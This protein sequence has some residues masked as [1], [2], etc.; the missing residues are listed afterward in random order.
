MLAKRLSRPERRGIVLVLVLAML[1]LLALIGVTFATFSGQSR[2]NNRNYQQSLLQ[3]QAEELMDFALA[4]LITDTSDVRSAIRG[5]SLA[6]DMFGNDASTNGFLPLNPTTGGPFFITGVAPTTL[7]GQAAV[8]LTT[9]IQSN[10]LNFFGFNFTRWI[11]KVGYNLNPG[12][13]SGQPPNQSFEI[14]LDNKTGTN[15][16]FTVA[17][18]DGDTQ[19]AP[20]PTSNP[21]ALFTTLNNPTLGTTTTPLKTPLPGFFLGQFLTGGTPTNNEFP[22]VLDGRWLRAFNGPGISSTVSSVTNVPNSVYG[23]FRYNGVLN[24]PVGNNVPP[25]GP[26]FVG[27]DEDYDACDLEN[28]F[29]AIQSADGQVTIPSFHRPAV[30]RN[31]TGLNNPVPINDW[32]NINPLNANNL[33]AGVA[34]SASRI[35]RPRNIDGHDAA[36]F[37][38]LVPNTATGQITYDVDNDADGVTDSVWLDLGFPARPDSSGRLYKPLFAFMVIGLNGRIPL[39]TAG[40]F[41]GN[42][43]GI[44]VVPGTLPNIDG[45]PSQALHL[46][47]SP[48][49]IDPTYALQNAFNPVPNNGFSDPIAAFA[50]PQIGVV[51]G[52]ATLF[53]HNSQVDNG[54]VDVRLTQYRN[55]LAGTRPQPN[56]TA[57]GSFGTNGDNNF[58]AI[59]GSAATTVR[60]PYFMPN[61]IAE[62]FDAAGNVIDQVQFDANTG[63]PY[64]ERNSPPVAGRWGEAQSIPGVPFPNPLATGPA[65]INVVGPNYSSQGGML[66][67]QVRAGYSMDIGDLMNGLPRDAADDNFNSF[68]PFPGGPLVTNQ[69]IGEV[70]DLDAYDSAGALLFPV[71]RMRRW[72]TPADINGTGSVSTWSP[73]A[74]APNR[75]A[76]ALGR[77]EFTSYFRPPGAPGV[78]NTNYTVAA[79][80]GDVTSSNGFALGSISF[81][82]STPANPNP[83]YTGGPANEAPALI[84]ASPTVAPTPLVSP[85]YLPDLTNNPLHSFESFRIPNQAYNPPG[86]PTPPPIF[87]PQQLGGAPT[88]LNFDTTPGIQPNP[89]PTPPLV[90]GAGGGAP[91]QYPTYDMAV[92]ANT[93]SDGLNEADEMNLYQPNPLLDAPFGPSDLEWLYRQQDVDGASLTSR[94]SQ[95]APISFTNTID[96]A[97]RRK[98]FS[99]DFWDLNNFVWTNDNPG[100]TF[101]TNS[102]FTSNPTLSAIDPA[103]GASVQLANTGFLSYGANRNAVSSTVSLAQRDKKINLNYPLPVSNDPN[104]PV[105]Q[106][107]I[108]DTYELLKVILPPK[109]VDTPEELAQLSQFVINIVDFRDPDCAMTHWVNPD[110]QLAGVLAPNAMAP[111]VTTGTTPVPPTSVTLEFKGFVPLPV[112]GSPPIQNIQLDQYGM[113]YNPVAINEVLAYSYQYITAPNATP[114][115]ANRFFAE[116]VNTLTSPELSTSLVP[117]V[118]AAL[119]NPALNLGGYAN[120][121]TTTANPLTIDPYSG[122]S[123]DIV[124]TA[125]DPYSRPDPY[126]G[127]LVPYGNTFG[128]TPLHAS[129]FTPPTGLP[130]VQATLTPLAQ[131]TAPGVTPQQP[132]IPLPLTPGVNGL[133]TDY[134][135]AFGNAAPGTTVELNS[136]APG[137]TWPVPAPN[138]FPPQSNNTTYYI[139]NN[140]PSLTQTLAVT[141]DPTVTPPP[142]PSPIPI[143][144]GCLP[145]PVL[146]TLLPPTPT[147]QNPNTHTLPVNYLTTIPVPIGVQAAPIYYW[148]CLRRPA[149]PF[150]PVSAINPM[151]VVDSVRF[152]YIEASAVVSPTSKTPNGVPIPTQPPSTTNSNAVYS[153]Q[154]FQPY[155]GGHAVPVPQVGTP[156]P[157]V[158]T[159]PPPPPVDPRYGYSEQIVVP[160]PASQLLNTQGIYFVE[161]NANFLGTQKVYH[162]LGWANEYEQGSFNSLAEPWDYFPFNDRDFTSV[163]EL[164]LVPGSSPGLFTKQFVEFA[165]SFNNIS[166]V[167][168]SPGALSVSQVVPQATGPTGL[169]N[170]NPA[171]GLG[172]PPIPPTPPTIFALQA[173]TTASTPL[174]YPATPLFYAAAGPPALLTPVAPPHT[175]P[176]LI[177]KFFYSAYGGNNTLDPGGVVGGYAADGW[178]KMFEF[179]EVPSQMIGAIG[180]VAN[181]MNFDWSRQDMKPGQL[182]LNLIIDEEVFF[183]VLGRQTIAQGNGQF[184][185]FS[186]ATG[187]TSP[188]TPHDQFT[189]T[190]LNFDQIQAIPTGGTLSTLAG[191]PSTLL[192][193]AGNYVPGGNNPNTAG[194]VAPWGLPL[195]EGTPPIPMVVTS[196]LANGAPA[197]AYPIWNQSAFYGGLLAL[198]PITGYFSVLNNP[199]ATPPQAT[200]PY[201]NGL[202]AAWIQFL[203]LRHG[204]SGYMYGYGQGA[205]GQ[206]VLI[207]SSA[208]VPGMNGVAGGTAI[209]AE[210]PFHSLSYPDIDFTVMRPAALPPG[211][212]NTSTAPP[213]ATYFTT[214]NAYPIPGTP[215][216]IL[217]GDAAPGTATPGTFP[218]QN[219]ATYGAAT[220][221]TNPVTGATSL[222]NNFVGDPGVRNYL[223]YT[224]YPSAALQYGN[225]TL[226]GGWTQFIQNTFLGYPT[227][228][229]PAPTGSVVPTTAS[230]P[231]IYWPVYPPAIPARRLFQI[232]DAYNGNPG[233]GPSATT[234]S[235]SNASETGDPTINLVTP[236]FPNP[237]VGSGLVTPV[238]TPGALP[239]ITY[240]NGTLTSFG[241]L[242]NSVVNLYWPGASAANLYP[243]TGGNP[244]TPTAVPLPG[245]GGSHY[246]GSS[247]TAGG[248]ADARQHPYWR[249]EHLQ[250][251]INQTTVRTHQYAVWI[252][253]GFFEVIRQGDLGMFATNPQLAFDILGPEIGAANG[254]TTRFRSFF[255]V[256]RLQLTGFTPNSPGAFHPAV[257]YRQ[258]IQ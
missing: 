59:N 27:M 170:R 92:N 108:S 199:P 62:Q 186:V 231:Y 90:I 172:P 203:M 233:V 73:A 162:T 91:L 103:S 5:H 36:T 235:A 254:K 165:P 175:F 184:G 177:D 155:R 144:Q 142:S 166:T 53:A 99:L 50:P 252:T 80:T 23:N 137:L 214:P 212:V 114:K 188:Q 13:G 44:E 70:N 197:S 210:I 55:I 10:D 158:G 255:L 202:K 11:M 126:R 40:N 95:L 161:G 141:I 194:N 156:T 29:L 207:G 85:A 52:L 227:I 88:D 243:S 7:N 201:S 66:G 82:S 8:N 33:T 107:W 77:V 20:V 96:G 229:T 213:A 84:A 245:G 61:G 224:G 46:G 248:R 124:F 157:P 237:L 140:T 111:P 164:L 148:A 89:P 76:D 98:L 128:L 47:N 112:A 132:S 49:E 131:G 185:S 69:H 43:G 106:K 16:V 125:D 9:N 72:L 226:P 241:V 169:P 45:G 230:S 4:Q 138:P 187:I 57:G 193:L 251:I 204:G 257:V 221:Y 234:P 83:F 173:Y 30:I 31:D 122:G 168:G 127:Q 147:N 75:G 35:L 68:D 21:V 123:W 22:F 100:N 167:F 109:A 240:V 58:V 154:R 171:I 101:P 115:R 17:P 118:G 130:A 152:P 189:Q 86:N 117:L 225:I 25:F 116:L 217:Y 238:P 1:G 28:W 253:I 110:V 200:P 250:R 51:S 120:T 19:N 181:G 78:I 220:V 87:M 6:R 190:N 163:A 48:S 71:E 139:P 119:F 149:D 196:T 215:T 151:V 153:V 150:A 93:H 65:L 105:R 18:F 64:T 79:A 60:T 42:V 133:V 219:P 34:D 205:V 2:I 121:A 246:L 97:R 256:D 179:L 94:L 37:P 228:P 216:N 208:T 3:P 191:G 159:V 239:P 183:S 81:P 113:E 102:S 104:D 247:A 134:F 24:P 211:A 195:A 258:R 14:L 41:A 74:T 15:R 178:F 176:Y 209:P 236:P 180:P 182:N 222:W 198:D 56:P 39:N 249:S 26:N 218:W 136:P 192:L 12:V 206:N 67:N 32:R 143:Y 174:A 63:L 145:N 38:D 223:L 244:L 160:G 135:Y 146:Q 129:S 232:P 242:T 54:G